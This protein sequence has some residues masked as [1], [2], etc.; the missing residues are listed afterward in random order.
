MTSLDSNLGGRY[1]F[2]PGATFLLLLMLAVQSYKSPAAS[3][4]I[5][6]VLSCGLANGLLAYGTFHSLR[7]PSWS[8]EV[9]LW[10]ADHSHVL[11]VWPGWWVN[12]AGGITYSGR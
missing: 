1:A 5:M 11:L 4:L 12:N 3:C 9:Q 10:Q 6:L 2:L 7:G 8:S